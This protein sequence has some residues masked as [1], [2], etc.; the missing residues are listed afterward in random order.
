MGLLSEKNL[1]TWV[2]KYIKILDMNF[3]KPAVFRVNFMLLVCFFLSQL[4]FFHRM[5]SH[6][7]QNSQ[8]WMGLENLSNIVFLPMKYLPGLRVERAF[9]NF[10]V[11]TEKDDQLSCMTLSL[12]NR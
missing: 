2:V 6:E 8:T 1:Y 10:R 3:Q 11:G 9:A 12:N 5:G 4:P 7:K